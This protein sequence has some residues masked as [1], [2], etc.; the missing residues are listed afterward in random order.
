[1]GIYG[2]AWI[3]PGQPECRGEARSQCAGGV[4]I[5]LT[6]TCRSTFNR[7]PLEMPVQWPVRVS[8]GSQ[9]GELELAEIQGRA[10]GVWRC[11]GTQPHNLS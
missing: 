2:T 9:P 6:M 1:M 5:S 8:W 11:Q 10:K 3:R 7:S 4:D